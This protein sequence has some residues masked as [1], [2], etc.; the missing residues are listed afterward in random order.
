MDKL[1][2]RI[3]F[4]Y[5]N[6]NKD[7]GYFVDNCID[8]KCDNLSPCD[9]GGVIFETFRGI[10]GIS[11]TIDDIHK[12]NISNYIYPVSFRFFAQ[13]FGIDK[14]WVWNEKSNKIDGKTFFSKISDK[15]LEDLRTKKAKLFLYIHSREHL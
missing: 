9:T 11:M 6:Y 12:K 4:G 5:E 3:V 14:P 1:D 10:G 7:E 15:V 8:F 2:N 13:G